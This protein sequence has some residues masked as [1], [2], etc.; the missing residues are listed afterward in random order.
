M[1]TP[2]KNLEVT[3]GLIA[4]A[5]AT[6]GKTDTTL[7][8]AVGSLVSGYRQGGSDSESSDLFPYANSVTFNADI[9][10]VTEDIV[11]HLERATS[12]ANMFDLKMISCNKITIYI[13]NL[14]TTMYRAFGRSSSSNQKVKEIVI[15][16]DTSNIIS[17]A[18]AFEGKQLLERVVGEFNFIN[19]TSINNTF[20]QCYALQ[21]F[22][23]VP[24]TI[25]LSLSFA[26]SPNL[27]DATIQAIIDGLADLTGQTAQTLTVHEDVEARMS[28]EQKATITG[29]NWTLVVAS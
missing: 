9:Q 23:P 18:Q 2:Q 27:S 4:T 28:E 25:K 26:H 24:N 10:E 14:C 3:R 22:Y 19:A 8:D 11:L 7:T 21:E 16:G 1:H 12:I 6:T 13:S 29:K 5:N 15:I 20:N 17:Y